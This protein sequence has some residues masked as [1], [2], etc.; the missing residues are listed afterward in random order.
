MSLLTIRKSIKKPWLKTSTFL[1]PIR[2][3]LTGENQTNNKKPKNLNST[4]KSPKKEKTKKIEIY[5]NNARQLS[6]ENNI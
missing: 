3:L 1:K 4:L 6:D 2:W 5:F